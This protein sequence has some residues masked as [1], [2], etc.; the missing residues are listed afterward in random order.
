MVR[1]QT[2]SAASLLL[3]W[4]AVALTVK[5]GRD[6]AVSLSLLMDS[7]KSCFAVYFWETNYN[8]LKWIPEVCPRS[9]RASVLR[10]LDTCGVF[11]I[12]TEPIRIGRGTSAV[13]W[14]HYQCY[15]HR[16]FYL[17]YKHTDYLI[18]SVLQLTYS[19]PSLSDQT[20]AG[21]VWF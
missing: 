7:H 21:L 8:H 4:P 6:G 2:L 1:K 5:P 19:S 13:C 17:F 20:T 16:Y 15:L 10:A 9:Y 3:I 14:K 11:W 12:K 18:F